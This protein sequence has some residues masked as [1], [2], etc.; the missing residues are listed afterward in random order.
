MK[1]KLLIFWFLSTSS[2]KSAKPLYNTIK[3]KKTIA[4][5][6]NNW[7]VLPLTSGIIIG[8]SFLLHRDNKWILGFSFLLLF[9]LM[10]Y[11]FSNNQKKSGS[12]TI[13]IMILYLFMTGLF[14]FIQMMNPNPDRIHKIYARQYEHPRTLQKM[15]GVQLPK[16]KVIDSRLVD[17]SNFDFEFK[18][19]ATIEFNTPPGEHF[20]SALDSICNLPVPAEPDESSSYFYYGLEGVYPCWRKNEDRYKYNRST[21]FGEKVLHSKD[22]YFTFTIEKGA[23]TANLRY[24]NH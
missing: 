22:A 13:G 18:T 5:I 24:G 8:G 15:M 21:D 10:I 19:E 6:F 1:I 23:K 7:W 12:S 4:Y 11:Q 17:L 16:F 9:A 3:M 2:Q 20:F 14:Y